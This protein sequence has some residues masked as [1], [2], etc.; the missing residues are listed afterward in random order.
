[1]YSNDTLDE[2]RK[3]TQIQW[4]MHFGVIST[5]LN[6]YSV[7][8][9]LILTRWGLC[10]N[11][12]MVASSELLNANTTS[13]DFQY[14]A[15]NVVL[16]YIASLDSNS[17]E[18]NETFPWIAKNSRRHLLLYFPQE[19]EHRQDDPTEELQGFHLIFHSNFEFPS[20][21]TKNHVRIND[22]SF[23]TID[24]NP[25]VHEADESLQDVTAYE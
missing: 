13:P 17:V 12:N 11:F 14:E 22:L 20:K 1:M 8:Y 21:G 9:S 7:P 3:I 19:H 2:M 23:V 18:L 15:D 16:A 24:F 4:F 10:F 6:K 5:W 25:I